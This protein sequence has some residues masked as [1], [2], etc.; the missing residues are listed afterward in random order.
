MKHIIAWL[1]RGRLD[2]FVEGGVFALSYRLDY[3]DYT[4]IGVMN[5]SSDRWPSIKVMLDVGH[6]EV[7]GIE[8]LRPDGKWVA[9]PSIAKQ[10]TQEG[11]ELVLP[12]DLGYL[13]LAVLTVDVT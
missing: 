6:R 7:R 11:I 10:E 1:N 5:L 12:T 3:P 13:E 9:L 4:V 8:Y 2:L